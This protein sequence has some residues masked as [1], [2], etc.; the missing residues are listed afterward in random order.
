MDGSNKWMGNIKRQSVA[1]MGLCA[2]GLGLVAWPIVSQFQGAVREPVLLFMA[3][4]ILIGFGL[5][6]IGFAL[7][8]AG[9]DPFEDDSDDIRETDDPD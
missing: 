3:L 8:V 5:I 1:G 6:A 9:A 7:M 4:P 2:A